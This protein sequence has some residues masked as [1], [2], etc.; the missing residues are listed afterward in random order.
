[1]AR[2]MSLRLTK[3]VGNAD[4]PDTGRTVTI[5]R[6]DSGVIVATAVETPA[7][8]GLYSA[9]FSEVSS[10]G[11]W[12]I[13]GV[14]TP[15]I[16]SNSPF[17]IGTFSY[18]SGSGLDSSG[19]ATLRGNTYLLGGVGIGKGSKNAPLDV[20]GNSVFSG[21]VTVE[22]NVSLGGSVV[23]NL[24]VTGSLGT[25]GDVTIGRKDET[26]ASIT[27]RGWDANIIRQTDGP[28]NADAFDFFVGI[29]DG[30]NGAGAYDTASMT[31]QAGRTDYGGDLSAL[32][33]KGGNADAQG[34]GGGHV[35]IVAGLG[36]GGRGDVHLS[37]SRIKLSSSLGTQVTGSMTF[38]GSNAI[39][40]LNY[41]GSRHILRGGVT[42]VDGGGKVGI[43]KGDDVANTLLDVVGA[44]LITGTLGV[45]SWVNLPSD[46]F[47]SMNTWLPYS[48]GNWY[49]R[50][51]NSYFDY[52]LV[53]GTSGG[54]LFV[55]HEAYFSGSSIEITGSGDFHI[56]RADSYPGTPGNFIISGSNN[57]TDVGSGGAVQIVGGGAA[58]Q[59]AA[60]GKVSL[61]GGLG[62]GGRGDIHL[63]GSRLRVQATAGSQITGSLQV[64]GSGAFTGSLS[65]KTQNATGDSTTLK[66]SGSGIY[67]NND[68]AFGE[69]GGGA[70]IWFGGTSNRRFRDLGTGTG[71]E[72]CAQSHANDIAN[73]RTTRAA[74]FADNSDV[75]RA[76]IGP[77]ASFSVPVSVTGSLIGSQSLAGTSWIG[78]NY[79][80]ALDGAYIAA[81]ASL[82]VTS[83]QNSGGSSPSGLATVFVLERD[84]IAAQAYNNFADF[85]LER[86]ENVSTNARTGLAIRLTHATSE[87]TPPTALYLRSDGRVAV[88]KTG[89][90]N[91]NL[92]V[93][94]SAIF[95]GSLLT[96]TAVTASVVSASAAVTSSGYMAGTSVGITQTVVIPDNVGTTHTLTFTKGILTA[97]SSGPS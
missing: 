47:G 38:S 89:S 70:G 73:F 12:A 63:S 17:W 54:D 81:S 25:S 23:T 87:A 45:T 10:W 51:A 2:Q 84:G 6:Q 56:S 92:D 74:R 76:I 66:V 49:V 33:L 78:G 30:I 1:M 42:L 15:A 71:I 68:I 22:G 37:G 62:D 7:G 35:K 55:V 82:M 96:T 41:A 48:D 97:Y 57:G 72:F 4:K 77:S 32:N 5:V 64:S 91:A 90:P 65:V 39:S 83:K 31:V 43:G 20:Y 69:I 9:S 59:G 46:G 34:V 13:D 18:V 95:S 79:A 29:K 28:G 53:V 75:E 58:A 44:A 93:S 21:S 11:Y 8:S 3:V 86:Y 61:I 67:G 88:N 50:N 52:N 40:Y 85:A 19:D 24:P 27:L 60:G 36:D 94:G 14:T 80:A 16:S 26:S